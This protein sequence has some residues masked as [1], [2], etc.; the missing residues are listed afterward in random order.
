M[1]LR[2]SDPTNSVKGAK[3]DRLLG[4]RLVFGGTLNFAQLQIFYGIFLQI[5]DIFIQ[6]DF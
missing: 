4:I 1:V 5:S 6:S 3:E 2:V